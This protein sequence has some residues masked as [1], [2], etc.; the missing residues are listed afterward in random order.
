MSVYYFYAMK[1]LL[2]VVIAIII[3]GAIIVVTYSRLMNR[4]KLTVNKPVI[5][6]F[7]STIAPKTAEMLD[8]TV[9]WDIIGKS[10]KNTHNQQDQENYLVHEIEQ[11]TPTQMIGFRLRTDKLLYDT[12]NSATWCAGYIMNGGCSDDGFEY[13]RCW[14]IS[15]GKE[16]Y[17]SA[18]V[19]PDY[20]IKEGVAG[21]H[22][23]EFE[24]VWQVAL[25]AFKNKTGKNLYDYVDY[26]KFKT[27]EGHYPQ[28]EFTWQEEHPE[29]M[30]KIC[31]RLYDALWGK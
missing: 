29:S 13:F 8:E 12:Y 9:F 28:I 11:L 6:T 22:E 7:D 16:T 25:T 31:P 24:G 20:L 19:N 14:I 23:Y 27:C 26:D 4:A 5:D 18:K 17:D 2:T 3:A 21:D 10:L 30:R 15:R 1:T